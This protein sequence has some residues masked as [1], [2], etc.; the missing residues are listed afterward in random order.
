M[1]RLPATGGRFPFALNLKLSRQYVTVA[2]H[3]RL[4][5]LQDQLNK[6]LT[7]SPSTRGK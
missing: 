7:A 5:G 1:K 4:I 3:G 6:S 2:A